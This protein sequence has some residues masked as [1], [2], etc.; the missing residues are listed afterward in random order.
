M[1]SR[2]VVR[3]DG[4]CYVKE[5]IYLCIVFHISFSY[6]AMDDR[7]VERYGGFY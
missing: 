5:K 7:P 6:I 1:G 3:Y 4:F 2:H